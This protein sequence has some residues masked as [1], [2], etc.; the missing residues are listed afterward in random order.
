MHTN[1][2]DVSQFLLD[3][4]AAAKARAE[5]LTPTERSAIARNAAV[6]RW[7]R[8]V[9]LATHSGVL[10]LSGTRFECAVLADTTRVIKQGDIMNALGR[11][12]SSGRRGDLPPFLEAA[13]LTEFIS[14]RLRSDL[15]GIEFRASGQRAISRGYKASILVDVCEVFLAARASGTVK[16]SKAQEGYAIRAEILMRSLAKLGIDALVDEA[17]GYEK[18]RER[19]ELQRLLAEYVEESFRPWVKRFPDDFFAQVLRIYGHKANGQRRPQFVGK[20]INEYVYGQLP[21][22][23]L[24]ELQRVNPTTG[25]GKRARTHHQHLTEGTGNVHLDRQIV[26]VTTLL[27]ISDTANDFKELFARRFPKTRQVLKVTETPHGVETLF[28]IE[29]FN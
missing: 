9:P 1:N 17:T 11:H 21:E 19:G 4:V 14:S 23:V 8:K 15:S 12:V 6:A 28:E 2:N 22:G 20:F 13:N 29:D 10:D 7:Q 26:A 27:A 16:L 18:T 24:D 5:S 3:P 25:A